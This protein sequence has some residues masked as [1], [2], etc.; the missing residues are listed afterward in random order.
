MRKTV[1]GE[2]TLFQVAPSQ[3][4]V[5]PVSVTTGYLAEPITMFSLAMKET[6]GSKAD[7]AEMEYP[8]MSL[9]LQ[10]LL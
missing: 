4:L 1:T 6:T 2:M 9:V 8:A 7:R 5:L 10:A 3:S